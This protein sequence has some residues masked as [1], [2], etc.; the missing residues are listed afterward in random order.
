MGSLHH[1]SLFSHDNNPKV[2]LLFNP[3]LALE[4]CLLLGIIL[5]LGR[6]F[7]ADGAASSTEQV[8]GSPH[9]GP[10]ARMSLLSS[11]LPKGESKTGTTKHEEQTAPLKL[12]VLRSWE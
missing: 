12:G 11:L 9:G 1:G 8:F 10:G 4:R 2:L 3:A 5:G 6:G 7:P